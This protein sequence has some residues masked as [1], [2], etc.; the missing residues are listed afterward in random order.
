[1]KPDTQRIDQLADEIGKV[2][3]EEL[4]SRIQ[5]VL[6]VRKTLTPSQLQRLA[7]CCSKK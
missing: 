3:T 4:K 7:N 6:L 2:R 5:S 1:D